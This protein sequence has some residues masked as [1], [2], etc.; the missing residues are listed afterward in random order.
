MALRRDQYIALDLEIVP[1]RA[2]QVTAT[3]QDTDQLERRVR[4]AGP[5][6]FPVLDGAHANVQ[7]L[8]TGLVRQP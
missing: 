2:V 3:G 1:C 4:D 8:R 6:S 5:A 7:K